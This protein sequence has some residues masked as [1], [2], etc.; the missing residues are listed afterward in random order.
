MSAA[1]IMSGSVT[2]SAPPIKRAARNAAAV[3]G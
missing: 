3:S 2:V 1:L